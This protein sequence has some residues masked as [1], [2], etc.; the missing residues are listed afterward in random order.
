MHD[1]QVLDP[2]TRPLPAVPAPRAPE[3]S[4]AAPTPTAPRAEAPRKAAGHAPRLDIQGLRAVA[5]L[6]VVVYHLRPDVL[7]G[8][9]VGV[10]VFFVISGF[11]IVGSLGREAARTGTISL[12]SFY[13][14]RIRRLLPASALVLL[15]V[16]AA[17]IVLMPLSRWGDT[18]RDLITSALNVQNWALALSDGYAAATEAVSPLQH[19]W[20]LAVEEQFYLVAP[21]LIIALV[22]L[23]GRL[24]RPRMALIVAGMVLVT[25]ASLV[26]SVWFSV[27]DHDV[28]YFATT[29]RM[30][31]LTAGG[32]LALAGTRLRLPRAVRE[33]AGWVGI[34]AIAASA[35][36]FTTEM[37]FPGWIA[38]VPVLGTVFV[39]MVGTPA[40]AAGQTSVSRLLSTRP[41]TFVGDIS[42]SLYLWH[43]PVIV[44][45]GFLV[46]HPPTKVECLVLLGVSIALA[47]VSTRF[48]EAP[49]RSG[50]S[51][52]HGG[53]PTRGAFR[54]GALLVA[55]S[56]AAGLGPWLYV[57]HRQAQLADQR[58]D[59]DHP[60]GAEV[61]PEDLPAASA[62]IIPDPAVADA[63]RPLVDDEECPVYDPRTMDR[64]ACVYGDTSSRFTVVL[65][66]DS[67]AGQ[68]STPLDEIAQAQG[69]RLQSMARNGCP[70]GAAP[71]IQGE[72]VDVD[73]TEAN[74][75]TRDQILEI[76]PRAV[77]TSAM[78]PAGY[79]QDHSWRWESFDQQV[80]GYRDLWGPLVAAGIPILV[81]RDNPT[82]SFV[83]PE[84]VERHGPDSSECVIPRAEGVDDQP[85]PLVA[86]AEGMD[87]VHVLDLTAHLCNS[88]V[89]PAVIGNVLVYRDNHMTDTFALSLAGPLQ[90][91]LTGIV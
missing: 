33:A 3:A 53:S 56:V 72:R 9:F 11:L 74:A 25:V 68:Y 13:A 90:E 22:W 79:A 65:T 54:L 14:K 23:A 16:M 77:V 2:S 48:V 80:Q 84:C 10:D 91:A 20:S 69:W 19:F 76:H 34:A 49:F 81:I 58:L 64:D 63:D 5:V 88:E 71:S 70:F 73:C 36:L 82:P 17:T 42:Y 31:E 59:A 66:G 41:A 51:T 30:W 29:T 75:I 7:R 44:F 60:G 85:D 12:R 83:G 21:V 67:H 40:D 55:A 47:W 8:G 38:V 50:R 39:I 61:L 89:C 32:L 1:T 86:A 43:W 15:A 52:R 78:N 24:A 26:H 35:Y 27:T 18:G 37:A 46:L 45:H 4:T 87:G 62:P 57:D 6:L 28:A